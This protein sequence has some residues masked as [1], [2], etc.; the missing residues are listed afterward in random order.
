LNQNFNVF[1][2]VALK[3]WPSLPSKIHSLFFMAA[4]VC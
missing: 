3:R 4:K 2:M 1:S